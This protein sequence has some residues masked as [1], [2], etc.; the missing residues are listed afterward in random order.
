MFIPVPEQRN[1]KR[2]RVIKIIGASENNLKN[3]DVSIPMNKFVCVTGVSGSGKSTLIHDILYGGVAKYMG[4]APPKVGKYNEIIGA[5]YID[6]I[7]IVDQTPIGKSPRSNP[8]SYIKAFDAP[9][10]SKRI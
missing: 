7:E 1:T 4:M 3:I 9:G 10:K 5:D 6:D 8:V 2:T